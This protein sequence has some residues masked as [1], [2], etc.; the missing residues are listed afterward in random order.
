M[1]VKNNGMSVKKNKQKN[2]DIISKVRLA[3]I[4]ISESMYI[5]RQIYGRLKVLV[6]KKTITVV[7]K[8][9]YE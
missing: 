8:S 1:K 4:K 9:R 7:N 3:T 2:S 5:L 6:R